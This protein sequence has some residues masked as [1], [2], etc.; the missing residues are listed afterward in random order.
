MRG[1]FSGP[2]GRYFSF[3]LLFEICMS[4]RR[5]RRRREERMRSIVGDFE[6]CSW[7]GGF[8][9][10]RSGAYSHLFISP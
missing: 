1:N 8:S 6:K 3:E 4:T 10:A 9:L 5:R 2:G 7:I